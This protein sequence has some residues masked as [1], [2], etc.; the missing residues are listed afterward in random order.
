MI[1]WRKGLTKCVTGNHALDRD[2]A[3][4]LE[5]GTNRN[6]DLWTPARSNGRFFVGG[7]GHYLN[8]SAEFDTSVLGLIREYTPTVQDD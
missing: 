8:R 5:M 4:E 7:T 2:G 3:S 6:N 1:G